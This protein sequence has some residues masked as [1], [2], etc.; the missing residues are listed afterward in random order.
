MASDAEAWWNVM[1][2][3][4]PLQPYFKNMGIT[5]GEAGGVL[6]RLVDGQWRS[7]LASAGHESPI[8]RAIGA[9]TTGE[10]PLNPANALAFFEANY[11]LPSDKP[12]VVTKKPETVFQPAPSDPSVNMGLSI[13]PT[14]SA[15]PEPVSLPSIYGGQYVPG[16]APEFGECP[17]H[18]MIRYTKLRSGGREVVYDG[19]ASCDMIR[20]YMAD[21]DYDVFYPSFV[22]QEPILESAEPEPVL[23]PSTLPE[24]EPYVYSAC[25]DVYRLS[26]GSVTTTTETVD[27]QTMANYVN[28]QH[29]LVREC[30]QS[31][32]STQEVK[33][34][35]GYF[36][37][38]PVTVSEPEPVTVL[39]PEPVTVTEPVV[40][41]EPYVYSACIDVYR[42]SNGNVTA[43]RETVDYETM[44]DYTN[45][46]HLLVR[47]CGK[48]IP[49]TQEVKEWYG[50]F[51]EEEEEEKPVGIPGKFNTN[52]LVGLLAGGV[53]AVPILD[54]LLKTKKKRRR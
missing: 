32:P 25:I 47:E 34:W 16:V 41:P 1:R 9:K 18:V 8:E 37:P 17:A 4:A 42:L 46:Q 40:E 30:G 13:I 11:P 15:E 52:I 26:N 48:A 49:S 3:Y 27:Y 14:A 20:R 29:L 33:G 38:E 43:T 24:E 53:L 50:Y 28:V 45:V 10:N 36:E 12:I 23:D 35:Y 31:I 2:N 7:I 21:P 5:G 19:V 54:D 22:D 51:E 44:A 6:R 39:E